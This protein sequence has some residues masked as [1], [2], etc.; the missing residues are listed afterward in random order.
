MT[1][2]LVPATPRTVQLLRPIARPQEL[3]AAQNETRAAVTELLQEGRDYGLIPGTQKKSLLQPGAERV[4]TAFGVVPKFRIATSEI[5][6]DRV[7]TFLDKRGAPRES[8]GFYRYVVECDLVL[9]ETGE[10][11]GSA[12]ASCSSLESKYISRPRD[13]E[14]T[15]L[16]MAEKRA[17]VRAT[18]GAFGLSDEFTQDMVDESEERQEQEQA[19]QPAKPK[20]MTIEEA[21][22][23]PFPYE[24]KKGAAGNNNKPLETL[25]IEFLRRAADWAIEQG[26]QVQDG[27]FIE[28]VMLLETAAEAAQTKLP[29][30]AP[31]T[32]SQPLSPETSSPLPESG[33]RP[34][35]HSSPTAPTTPGT[36]T[37]KDDPGVV[38]IASMMAD[39]VPHTGEA[40]PTSRYAI[41]HELKA[42]IADP[43]IAEVSGGKSLQAAAS[44]VLANP[45]AT[46]AQLTMQRDKLLMKLPASA[47]P[48]PH[49]DDLPF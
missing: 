20:E 37:L 49:N 44:S 48:A 25:P 34:T 30:D 27:R 29:F 8:L 3:M 16:Q 23:F 40:D 36:E 35:P 42:L 26:R 47:A 15:V 13:S 41:T 2:A 39:A 4:N 18:R 33:N 46:L 21:R 7:N 5:D 24:R 10:T 38:P 17:V 11:V 1:T 6:H 31:A 28:A 12:L 45:K 22:A 14:N 19:Q 32:G 43:A 9:R